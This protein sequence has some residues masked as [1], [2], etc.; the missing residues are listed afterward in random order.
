[1]TYDATIQNRIDS[2][3]DET[4]N[5]CSKKMFGGVCYLYDG[6]MA[7]GIWHEYLIVRLGDAKKAQTAIDAG[8][9]EPFDVTGKPMKGWVMI[10]GNSLKTDEDYLH[11]LTRG[12]EF[13]QS[14][15]AK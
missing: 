7:F 5:F 13:A 8:I 3:Y 9:A 1:M 14:L 12:L 4:P 6:N 11:W 10:P 2:L 15:P